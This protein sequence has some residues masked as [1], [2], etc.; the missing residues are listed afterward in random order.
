MF[1]IVMTTTVPYNTDW[2]TD[3]R[4]HSAMKHEELPLMEPK[5]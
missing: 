3:G 2:L 4:G 1:C 5:S